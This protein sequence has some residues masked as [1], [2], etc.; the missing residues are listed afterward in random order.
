MRVACTSWSGIDGLGRLRK[1]ERILPGNMMRTVDLLLLATLATAPVVAQVPGAW[2]EMSLT[3]RPFARERHAMVYDVARGES[4]LFGGHN[5]AYMGDTWTLGPG[6]WAR[7]FPLTSPSPRADH[8]MAYDPIRQRVVL[9]GGSN[10]TSLTDIWEWDGSTWLQRATGIVGI[11]PSGGAA[12]DPLQGGT[13]YHRNSANLLW[14][15]N[16]AVTLT[17]AQ[18][19]SASIPVVF[20]AA[21]GGILT[22]GGS[23]TQR[24]QTVQGWQTIATGQAFSSSQHALALDPIRNRVFLN[25]GNGFVGGSS[26]SG[27]P[28]TWQWNGAYWAQVSGD[29]VTPPLYRHAMVFDF[30][31]DT[32]VLFGGR[33]NN[34]SLQ[35]STYEW[36]E[37]SGPASYTTYGSAC[38]GALAS[39][40]RL[41]ANPLWN[42]APVL[43]GQFFVLTDQLEPMQLVVGLIGFSDQQ[44]NGL[45]LPLPLDGLGMPGC[46]LLAAPESTLLLGISSLTGS[47]D[48]ITAIPADQALVGLQFF[49]QVVSIAP[50]ANP[51]GLVWS[52]AGHGTIGI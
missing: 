43:G 15:G 46:S 13:F 24:F 32:F 26:S 8:A 4:V 45:S 29:Q 50:T 33:H 30:Q 1:L 28:Y 39:A 27:Q 38:A 12:Y 5:G 52:N 23:V 21:S 2:V 48:W 49:Q 18:P 36:T 9:L 31:R 20:H 35:D 44:W 40:P 14:N 17:V 25:G 47:A 3:P 7:R 37:V 22:S 42:V 10:G 6:G 11:G 41:R 16:N 19:T 51:A 34:G